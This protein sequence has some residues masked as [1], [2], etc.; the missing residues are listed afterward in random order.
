[1]HKTAY[2]VTLW[3]DKPIKSKDGAIAIRA[4][5]TEHEVINEEIVKVTVTPVAEK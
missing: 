4:R 5:L 3:T 1:M 2:V